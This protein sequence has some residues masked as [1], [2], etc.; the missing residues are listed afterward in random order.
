MLEKNLIESNDYKTDVTGIVLE[1]TQS[2]S[3]EDDKEEVKAVPP[4]KTEPP[5]AAPEPTSETNGSDITPENLLKV[6]A[7]EWRLELERLK[8]KYVNGY[9]KKKETSSKCLVQ[10]GHAEIEGDTM[11]FIFGN[12]LEV[13]TNPEFQ[14]TVEQINFQYVRFDS[15]TD[16]NS[17]SKLKKFQK[18]SKL[19][20]SHNFLHSFVQ[21]AKLESLPHLTSL[22]IENNDIIKT[23]MCRSFIVYRFPHV[24]IINNEAVNEMDRQKSRKL[25]QYFD[26]VLSSPPFFAVE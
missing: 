13:L 16:H 10:S 14:K 7:Q 6:I 2:M 22:T 23:A 5:Q 8:T 1:K 26:R 9:R 20:F 25:F 12:A 11:L 19:S 3:K 18:L 4:A 24:V 17:L 15:I 21:I